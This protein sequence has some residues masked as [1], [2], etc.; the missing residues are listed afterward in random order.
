MHPPGVSFVDGA[1]LKDSGCDD[2]TASGGDNTDDK[3]DK[4]GLPPATPCKKPLSAIEACGGL[5]SAPR[6]NTQEAEHAA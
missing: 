4:Q 5:P 3:G 6:T 1:P 2:T